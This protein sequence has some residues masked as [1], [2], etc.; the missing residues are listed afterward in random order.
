MN[1][2]NMAE[3]FAPEHLSVIIVSLLMGTQT[4]SCERSSFHFVVMWH[5]LRSRPRLAPPGRM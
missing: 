5:T 3:A 2:C 4:I 1:M